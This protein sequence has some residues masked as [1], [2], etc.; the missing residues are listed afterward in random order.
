MNDTTCPGSQK[1]C[2]NGCGSACMDVLATD[3]T[4]CTSC[5]GFV[6]QS[7]QICP[8]GSSAGPV[9]ERS[10]S[11]A[12]QW[13]QTTCPSAPSIHDGT[14]PQALCSGFAP[15]NCTTDNDC[16]LTEKCC[17]NGCGRICAES[18]HDCY[19]TGPVCS[20][21]PIYTFAPVI[22]D[23]S[24]ECLA[25]MDMNFCYRADSNASC[26]WTPGFDPCMATCSTTK[27]VKECKARDPCGCQ[28]LPGCGW[29]EVSGDIAV[30]DQIGSY[31][32]GVCMSSVIGNKC[33][34]SAS[35][36]GYSGHYIES[37]LN[38]AEISNASVSS[39]SF[40]AAEVALA[41]GLS[42]N[43]VDG[44]GLVTGY[45]RIAMQKINEGVVSETDLQTE[46]DT[47]LSIPSVRIIVKNILQ[48]LYISESQTRVQTI[49]DVY[50]LLNPDIT[51]ICN[52]LHQSYANVLGIEAS[53]FQN[54]NL[55]P[56]VTP[57]AKRQAGLSSTYIHSSSIIQGSPNS[58]MGVSWSGVV[59]ALCLILL[60]M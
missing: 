59:F 43:L 38:C 52:A 18:V 5:P 50:N 34:A 57:M 20:D 3:P 45:L 22:P 51:R 53:H 25:C 58:G 32:Y 4:A 13:G 48:A 24:P 47:F 42:P 31:S 23:Q 19:V 14:C 49:L 27:P 55:V 37:I 39:P 21:R 46:L 17:F 2:S 8:D 9:C 12:C 60:A 29:C 7:I 56:V 36:Y 10:S 1:C 54:C 15:D 28:A 40:G 6:I 41:L 16:S 11:G 35:S 33:S 30:I 26:S 44:S